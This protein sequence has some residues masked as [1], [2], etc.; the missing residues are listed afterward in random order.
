MGGRSERQR[1]RATNL[2]LTLRYMEN[3]ELVRRRALGEPLRSPVARWLVAGYENGSGSLALGIRISGGPYACS[4]SRR[5][6]MRTVG[7]GRS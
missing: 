5:R 6:W 1:S 3:V 7:P 4:Q 2:T